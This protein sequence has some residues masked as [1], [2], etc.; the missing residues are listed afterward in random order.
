MEDEGPSIEF[1]RELARVQGVTPT[2]A[3]LQAVLGFLRVLLPAFRELEQEIPT[4]ALP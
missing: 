1:L 4:D 3:D 2:D